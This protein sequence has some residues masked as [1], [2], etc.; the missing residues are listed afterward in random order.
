MSSYLLLQITLGCTFVFVLSEVYPLVAVLVWSVRVKLLSSLI[1][2]LKRILFYSFTWIVGR[3]SREVLIKIFSLRI[4][5]KLLYCLSSF[6]AVNREFYINLI[7][8]NLSLFRSFWVLFLW[9]GV[10]WPLSEISYLF[11]KFG[12]VSC[13]IDLCIFLPSSFCFGN[14]Y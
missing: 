3:F 14:Y 6:N 2:N 10:V 1:L 11:F 12:E 9:R 5:K 4:L 13:H 7:V 8:T